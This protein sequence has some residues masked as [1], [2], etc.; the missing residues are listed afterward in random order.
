LVI[1]GD[2][3]VRLVDSG[4]QFGDDLPVDLNPTLTDQFLAGAPGAHTSAS[5]DFLQTFG[6]HWPDVVPF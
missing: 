3:V 6:F 4:A 2:L 1:Y 5:H